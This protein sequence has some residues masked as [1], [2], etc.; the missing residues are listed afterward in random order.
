[1]GSMD[2][3]RQNRSLGSTKATT[4]AGSDELMPSQT[5]INI[6]FGALVF[7]FIS[8]GVAILALAITVI[9]ENW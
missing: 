4:T 7:I 9:R 2:G 6:G 1:M 8:V 3:N 5:L